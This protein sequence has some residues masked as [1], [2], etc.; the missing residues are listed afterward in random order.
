MQSQ[1]YRRSLLQATSQLEV[2]GLMRFVRGF[3]ETYLAASCSPELDRAAQAI[4][5]KVFRSLGFLAGRE[6]YEARLNA[7]SK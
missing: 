6:G 4:L 7:P 2:T 5:R 1:S 3:S